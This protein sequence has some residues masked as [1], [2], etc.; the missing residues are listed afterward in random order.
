MTF[1]V[2]VCQPGLM[3]GAVSDEKRVRVFVAAGLTKPVKSAG[4]YELLQLLNY[5]ETGKLR[6][7]LPSNSNNQSRRATGKIVK[8]SAQQG[9]NP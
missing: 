8:K 1:R 3:R 9:V 6:K 5:P 4:I 2:S 7:I